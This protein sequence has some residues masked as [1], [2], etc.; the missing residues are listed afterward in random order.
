MIQNPKYWE[1]RPLSENQLKYAA[2]DVIYLK[3][4]YRLL[5]RGLKDPEK[6]FEQGK[7]C[8]FY[9]HINK[10]VGGIEYCKPQ[11]YISAFIK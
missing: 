5:S 8:L 1:Q 7:R 11:K 10:D 9:P 4:I 3:S 6:V 2:T